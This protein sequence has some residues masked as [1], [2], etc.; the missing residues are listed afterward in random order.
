[1]ILAAADH[2][3][4]PK[5]YPPP[6]ELEL[7]WQCKAF[8]ALPEPG[9]VRDQRA[10]EL[11]RALTALNVYNAVR[12]WKTSRDWNTWIDS[13]PGLWRIVGE[14]INLRNEYGR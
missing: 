12:A 6:P 3:E 8:D 11:R 5:K 7:A 4:N 9:G 14:V 10:G 1:M 2:A 13:N